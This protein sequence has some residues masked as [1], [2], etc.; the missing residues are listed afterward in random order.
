MDGH[1]ASLTTR[2]QQ[3]ASLY[4]QTVYRL[5]VQTLYRS[6]IR[7]PIQQYDCAMFK[8]IQ[9]KK[10]KVYLPKCMHHANLCKTHNGSLPEGLNAIKTGHPMLY[11]VLEVS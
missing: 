7:Y 6:F 5:S 2:E 1:G 10:N 9:K 11:A 8:L 3:S 4:S